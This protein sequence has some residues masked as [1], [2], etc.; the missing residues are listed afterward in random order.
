MP[1]TTSSTEGTKKK[2]VKRWD[3]RAEDFMVALKKTLEEKGSRADLRTNVIAATKSYNGRRSEN[4]CT[5]SRVY[6]RVVKL[7]KELGLK[8]P[9]TSSAV[10]TDDRKEYWKKE[11]AQYDGD[12]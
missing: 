3:I 6:A 9:L 4:N 2:R 8:L 7:R 1:K 11:L 5:D 10:L 12:E